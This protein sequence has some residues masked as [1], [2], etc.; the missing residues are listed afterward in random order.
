[1]LYFLLLNE[2]KNHLEASDARIPHPYIPATK[3]SNGNHQSR[4]SEEELHEDKRILRL[5]QKK[6]PTDLAA[7]PADSIEHRRRVH[8]R[9]SVIAILAKDPLGSLHDWSDSSLATRRNLAHVCAC[10]ASS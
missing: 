7:F 2:S 10:I 1:M 4:G 6:E 8:Q 5:L 9:C 3:Y